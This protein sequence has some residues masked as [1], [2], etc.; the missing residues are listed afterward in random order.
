MNEIILKRIRYSTMAGVW[1]KKSP[2]FH[3]AEVYYNS[4]KYGAVALSKKE[5]TEVLIKQIE[6]I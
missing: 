1:G 3:F 4:K 5:V 2:K 6:K